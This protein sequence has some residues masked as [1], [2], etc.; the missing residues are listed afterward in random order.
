V[1]VVLL[2]GFTNSTARIF[3]L[4]LTQQQDCWLCGDKKES[5]KLIVCHCPLLACKRYRTLGCTLL[6][7]KDLENIGVNSLTH[8]SL[9]VT[10]GLA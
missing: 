9:A 3:N 6:K 8:I 5:S 7:P 1:A 2:T 4:R 10:Q